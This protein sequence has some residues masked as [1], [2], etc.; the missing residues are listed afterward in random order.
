M[1][2]DNLCL[3]LGNTNQVKP[4][5]PE[6]LVTYGEPQRPNIRT[7]SQRARFYPPPQQRSYYTPQA[8]AYTPVQ[9]RPYAHA[10]QRTYAQP[11]V[12]CLP[13]VFST[14][15]TIVRANAFK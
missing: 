8:R 7:A 1:S 5:Y 11:Q 9:P 4:H 2:K 6:A 10:Q 3:Y 14:D 13:G 15:E 12:C